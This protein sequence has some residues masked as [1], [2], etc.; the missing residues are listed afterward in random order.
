MNWLCRRQ[1]FTAVERRPASRGPP[2]GKT[3]LVFPQFVE[4]TLRVIPLQVPPP[5]R[6]VAAWPGFLWRVLHILVE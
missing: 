4:V 1:D 3:P 6:L 5:D 2:V